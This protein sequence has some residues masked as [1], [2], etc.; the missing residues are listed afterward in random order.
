VTIEGRCDARFEAV[1]DAFRRNFAQHGEVGAA[2]CVCVDG[3]NVVDLWGGYTTEA[4]TRP[5]GP[6]TL[7]AVFSVGKAVAALAALQ[8]V[9]RGMLDLDA[10]VSRYW[11]EFAARG[12]EAITVRQLLCHRA[13]LPAIREP[14]P[15]GAM[16]DWELMTSALAG[17]QPWWPPGS[18]HGYHVNTF[19]YLIGETVRRVSG[20]SIGTFIREEIAKPLG[21]D[22][23]LGLAASEDARTAEFI[24]SQVPPFFSV[25]PASEEELMTRNTYANP[26]GLSGIGWVNR[27]AWR[28]AEIPS[29]NGHASARGV[30]RIYAALAAGGSI[31]G[32]RIIGTG[33]LREAVR[34][35]SAGH[36]AI[37]L[38]PS[39]FGLGFQLTYPRAAGKGGGYL[40]LL[41]NP[42]AF[43]HFGAGGSLGFADPEARVAFGY[44]MNSMGP[45]WSNPR[46]RALIEAFYRCL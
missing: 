32:I 6:E 40:P 12:K 31:D 29:T 7:V 19:G 11:P 41:P 28:A 37:L 23:H 24:W 20:C 18:R 3:R 17:Q 44:A 22:F 39:R 21:A 5:W 30:A 34:E 43:G 9:D 35:H 16:L 46:P 15:D 13:G 25:E 45:R 4:G 26:P 10:S 27:R 2:L 36:D 14:L 33:T 8:L 42:G 1:R 38:R